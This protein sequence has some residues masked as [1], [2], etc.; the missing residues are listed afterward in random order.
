MHH[1]FR[2]DFAKL[3]LHAWSFRSVPL[4]VMSEHIPFLRSRYGAAAVASAALAAAAA[5]WYTSRSPT[6]E[7]S[8]ADSNPASPSGLLAPVNFKV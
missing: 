8:P 2:R 5:A 7:V 3:V 6:T 1:M 4:G